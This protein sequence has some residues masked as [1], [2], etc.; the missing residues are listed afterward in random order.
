[1]RALRSVMAY[2][3]DMND[4]AMSQQPNPVSMYGHPDDPSPIAIRSRRPTMVEREPST[5]SSSTSDPS[6]SHL[7]SPESIMALRSGVSSQTLS[8]A[9]TDSSSSVEERKY[10]DNKE[11]RSKIVQEIVV[12]VFRDLKQIPLLQY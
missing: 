3:K 4:L 2:L 1:M 9:T 12:S 10:K 8:V 7:R 6:S 11:K 5:V